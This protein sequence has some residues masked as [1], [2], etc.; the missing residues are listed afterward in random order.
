[1]L[2][3]SDAPT[4]QIVMEY[5]LNAQ[6]KETCLQVSIPFSQNITMIALSTNVSQITRNISSVGGHNALI[7]A[8]KDDW[9]WAL[10]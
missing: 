10:S 6:Q 2:H 5:R 1:M 4:F 8:S 9:I 3:L 7:F